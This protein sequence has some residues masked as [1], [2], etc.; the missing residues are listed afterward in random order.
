LLHRRHGTTVNRPSA[1]QATVLGDSS[2]AAAAI[3]I[4]VAQ[5]ELN[6]GTVIFP[7]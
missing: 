7:V 6:G 2:I 5:I 3:A 4:G 1:A